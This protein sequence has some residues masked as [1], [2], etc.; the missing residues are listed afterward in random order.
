MTG[1]LVHEWIESTGGAEV[2]LEGMVR[3]FPGADIQCLWNDASDR[4]AGT[5][6]RETWMARTPLRRHKALGLPFEPFVWRSLSSGTS[7][8]WM[9]VSSHLFA[10]HARIRGQ[11]IPKYVY[12]HTPARYIWAPDLDE[13]GN[14]P[15]VRIAAPGYRALD[16]RR[17]AEATAIAANSSFVR[18]RIARSWERDAVVIHPPVPTDRILAVSD[19]TSEVAADGERRL[20]DALPATFLLGASRFVP[21]KRLDLVIAAAERLD[22]PVVIAG[23][24]PD[25]DRL[26]ALAAAARV[27]A[28]VILNPSTP[29]LYALLQRSAA[30]V[31]PPVED[32]GILPVEAQAVGTPVA[33]GPVGGQTEAVTPGVSGIIA[34][35][36]DVDGFAAAID[37]ALRVR[38]FDAR[39]V[40]ERFSPATFQRRIRAF[41]GGAGA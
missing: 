41:V 32:F 9:L 20:L 18:E 24:G 25:T 36:A 3:A 10:H 29:T 40:T 21:Y 1:L 6:V 34:E 2:V 15:L 7:Y 37:A 35:S 16:R 27:P 39:A 14:N 12:A 38:S 4:F 28:Q 26:T 11:D 22:L 13:R 19:W 33:V 5:P 30:Y 17:A 23:R 31:F 8:D